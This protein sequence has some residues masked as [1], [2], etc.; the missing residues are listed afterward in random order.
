MCF[1]LEKGRKE[2]SPLG[3]SC[4]D[5]SFKIVPVVS[6]LGEKLRDKFISI[7]FCPSTKRLSETYSCSIDQLAGFKLGETANKCFGL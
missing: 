2:A 7:P 5:C 6:F 3:W 4:G 1:C